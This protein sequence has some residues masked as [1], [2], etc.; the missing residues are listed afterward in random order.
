[1]KFRTVMVTATAAAAALSFAAVG[2]AAAQTLGHPVQRMA[3]S[4]SQVTGSRLAKGLLPAS[5]YGADF[6]SARP[7]DTG[8]SL[9]STRVLQTPG[10]LSCGSWANNDNIYYKNWGN[11]AG[12]AVGYFNSG[13]RGSWPFT[14]FDVYQDVLQFA[15]DNAANSFFNLAY[16]KFARCRTYAVASPSNSPGGGL[17]DVT[18]MA[19]SKTTVSGHK[20]F[21]TDESWVPSQNAYITYYIG[22]LYAVSGTNVYYLTE[23]IGTNDTPSPTLMSDL[24]H[25][26][27]SLYS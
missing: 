2:S 17:Y 22:V 16:S 18:D 25:R 8:G 27:Q 15:T 20:G 6:K 13:W 23:I 19:T 3:A 12:A 24:I 26:V 5:A 14:Q 21:A 9:L 10:S 1:M 7:S 4:A 11:T